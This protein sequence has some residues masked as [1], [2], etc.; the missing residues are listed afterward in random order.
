MS[1]THDV[2]GQP[3]Q[4]GAL[5]Q[6]FHGAVADTDVQARTELRMDPA[7]AMGAAGG[8]VDGLGQPDLLE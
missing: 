7:V 5:H 6:Q 3:V 4:A 2:A 1:V 8:G